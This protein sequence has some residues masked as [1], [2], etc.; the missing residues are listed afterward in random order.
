M[1]ARALSGYAS[2][3]S[4]TSTAFI[5]LYTPGTEFIGDVNYTVIMESKPAKKLA[6]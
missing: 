2:P 5:L 6:E 4:A 1:R 3:G